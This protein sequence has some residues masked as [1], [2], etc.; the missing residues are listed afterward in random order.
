MLYRNNSFKVKMMKAPLD[1]IE[2][3]RY[4]LKYADDGRKVYRI[5]VSFSSATRTVEEWAVE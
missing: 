3:K 5:G 4:A 1:Q 2:R